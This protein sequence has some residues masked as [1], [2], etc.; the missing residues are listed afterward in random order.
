MPSKDSRVHRIS[1]KGK[2]KKSKVVTIND[3]L[4]R[5]DINGILSD[6]DKDKPDIRDL[7]VI[8]VDKRDKSFSYY[9]TQDTLISTATW[10]LEATKLDLLTEQT[11]DSE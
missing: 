9:L 6:L 4:T 10:M 7:I 11:D 5:D 2:Q 1:P 8:Y 3:L